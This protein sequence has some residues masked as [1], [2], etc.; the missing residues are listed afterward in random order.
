MIVDRGEDIVKDVTLKNL[1]KGIE[2]GYETVGRD[3]NLA[4]AMCKDED[5]FSIFRGRR[6]VSNFED[7]IKNVSDEMCDRGMEKFKGMI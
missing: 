7:R 3:I 4:P 5:D 2:Q 6:E 1:T